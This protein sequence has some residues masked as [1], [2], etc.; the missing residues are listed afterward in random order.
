VTEFKVDCA[1]LAAVPGFAEYPP[2][3][4]P[5][6]AS[7]RSYKKNIE[8]LDAA[9]LQRLHDDLLKFH[10]ASYQYN[11]PGASPATHLGFIIDDVTPSPSVA[12]N[13][14]T[15]DLYGYTSMAV[16]AVQTQAHEIDALKH[17]VESLRAQIEPS[18]RGRCG[19][20][21]AAIRRSKVR[22]RP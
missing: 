13:G 21:T 5:A 11:T 6:I 7:R 16:A 8:Y 18:T 4:T 12:A 2:E 14:N 20:R 17:E 19:V 15:V 1:T 22:E 9:N 3:C 10:L